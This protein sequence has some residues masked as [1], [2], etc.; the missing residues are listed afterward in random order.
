MLLPEDSLEH[1]DTERQKIKDWNN[2]YQANSKQ[3]KASLLIYIV[4]KQTSSIL[5][6]K[7]GHY[8][9]IKII[10]ILQENS[11]NLCIFCTTF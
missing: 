5:R 2:I 10:I 1:N 6:N 11:I 9:I 7:E 4:D 8:L 3:K